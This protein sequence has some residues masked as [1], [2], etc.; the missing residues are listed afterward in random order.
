MVGSGF[1]CGMEGEVEPMIA[2]QA[3]TPGDGTVTKFSTGPAPVCR[4]R[5][6]QELRPPRSAANKNPAF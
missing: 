3:Y 6:L 2:A 5:L 1:A 4:Q